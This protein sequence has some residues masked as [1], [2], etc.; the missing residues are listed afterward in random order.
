MDT[1]SIYLV[2][3]GH[4]VKNRDFISCHVPQR[5]ERKKMTVGGI[6]LQNCLSI[7]SFSEKPYYL[8]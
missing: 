8:P 3:P 1:C 4:M 7:N 5:I 6:H 2:Y